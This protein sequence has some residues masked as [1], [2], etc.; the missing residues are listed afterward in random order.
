MISRRNVFG[1]SALTFRSLGV[2]LYTM[3]TATMPFDDRDI[4]SFLSCIEKGIYPEPPEVSESAKDLLARMLDPRPV[5]RASVEDILSHPWLQQ[6]PVQKHCS[7]RQ[8]RHA[9]ART[10]TS[11]HNHHQNTLRLLTAPHTTRLTDRKSPPTNQS[12]GKTP[13]DTAAPHQTYPH[14]MLPLIIPPRNTNSQC[15]GF[16]SFNFFINTVFFFVL[17]VHPV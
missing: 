2:I 5:S 15:L 17:Y 3:L 10:Y 12:S 6:Q 4:P 16:S 9:A 8:R 11:E 14:P 1:S 13:V 7:S